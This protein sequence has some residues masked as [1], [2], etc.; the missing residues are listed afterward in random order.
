MLLFHHKDQFNNA[1]MEIIAVYS[2]NEIKNKYT[3]WL[4]CRT[5]NAKTGGTYN[6]HCA[7]NG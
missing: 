5:F 7:L 6:N 2:D 1:F 3:L 4:K